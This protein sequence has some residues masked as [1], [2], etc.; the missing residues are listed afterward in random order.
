MDFSIKDQLYNR[1]LQNQKNKI[2]IGFMNKIFKFDTTNYN[3]TT[4]QFSSRTP[5]TVSYGTETIAYGCNQIWNSIP[6]EI[7]M[8]NSL[9]IFKGK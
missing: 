5:K 2:G 9:G 6:R 1:N 8:A 3:L 4:E 7:R